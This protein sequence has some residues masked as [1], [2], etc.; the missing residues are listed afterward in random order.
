MFDET[1]DGS[2]TQNG[3]ARTDHVLFCYLSFCC[4]LNLNKANTAL[5]KY[6]MVVN[7]LDSFHVYKKH[8]IQSNVTS[9]LAT[10]RDM[11]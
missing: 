7:V 5:D 6:A 2:P 10:L 9:P 11:L 1:A 8:T 3:C 4:S